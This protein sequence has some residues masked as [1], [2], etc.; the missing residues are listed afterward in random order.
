MGAQDMRLIGLAAVCGLLCGS[1]A[2]AE[3]LS[4]P[5]SA[6]IDN[7][8]GLSRSPAAHEEFICHKDHEGLDLAAAEPLAD[9]R[10]RLESAIAGGGALVN[11]EIEGLGCAYCAAAIEKA[12]A[13]RAEVTAAYVNTHDSTLSFV[14]EPG[15]A[16]ED[17]T[18]RKLIKRR[19]YGV[20]AIRRD[21]PLHS[22]SQEI[23]ETDDITPKR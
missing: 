4:T 6:R 5:P 22:A 19:G 21:M 9:A 15:D 13:A 12:F 10:T 16:L 8:A 18:I 17:R 20:G 3:E 23:S 1:A 14:E 7:P 2:A 11:V